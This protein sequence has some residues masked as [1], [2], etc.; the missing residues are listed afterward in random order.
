MVLGLISAFLTIL[1]CGICRDTEFYE[2]SIFVK[3]RSTLKINFHSTTGERDFVDLD[4]SEKKEELAYQEFV[5]NQKVYTDNLNRLWFL[6]LVLIQLTLT[7]LLYGTNWRIGTKSKDLIFHFLINIIPL[8]IIISLML[9]NEQTW[10][11][12]GLMTLLLTINFWTM[13]IT[14]RKSSVQLNV[15]A[16][17]R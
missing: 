13:R 12:I 1:F 5:V 4:E 9:F 16:M 17:V 10:R 2:P 3:H 6:P 8:T 15:S 11:L 14:R 7:F